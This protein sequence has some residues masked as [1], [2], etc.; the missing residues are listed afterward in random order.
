MARA[1]R[2]PAWARVLG[3][4][5]EKLQRDARR[6]RRSVLD[7]YGATNPAE[8]FAVATEAFFEKS[9]TLK[10]KHP[11]LYEELKEFYRQDPASLDQP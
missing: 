6:G 5:F 3:E 10:R 2:T 1:V 8:F 9:R 11:D 7:R 4:A